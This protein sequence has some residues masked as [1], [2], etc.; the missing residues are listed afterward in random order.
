M[1][2]FADQLFQY[3]AA[4][5]PIAEYATPEARTLALKR[6]DFEILNF[7]EFKKA[8]VKDGMSSLLM[9]ESGAALATASSFH[10]DFVREMR[11]VLYGHALLLFRALLQHPGF[12]LQ[13][14]DCLDMKL[15]ELIDRLQIRSTGV[16]ASE[17]AWSKGVCPAALPKD[18]TFSG[19]FNFSQYPQKF[20]CRLR[21][22]VSL[23]PVPDA[24]ALVDVPPGY[25]LV[26]F[27]GLSVR[28]AR[29]AAMSRLFTG[30]RL[31]HCDEPLMGKDV[32]EEVLRSGAV[33]PLKSG[34]LP[35]MYASKALQSEN[36]ADALETFS[37]TAIRDDLLE[38]VRL[39]ATGKWRTI[40]PM[41]MPSLEDIM[42]PFRPYKNMEKKIY[43]PSVF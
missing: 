20:P 18:V 31:T 9:A 38:E 19:W 7:P 4:A 40:V 27:D 14:A 17:K 8:H 21:S 1:E 6:L 13:H 22:H 39:K 5:I 10:N 24:K 28:K 15:E 41:V 35:S 3:G 16:P 26:Y 25:M 36:R 12:A 30:W 29:G 43:F 37:V 34:N 42:E 33:V 2:D 23:I 32:L 11:L